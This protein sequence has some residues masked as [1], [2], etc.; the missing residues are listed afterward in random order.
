[1]TMR[2]ISV[3]FILLNMFLWMSFA[4][5]ASKADFVGEWCYRT[6]VD[7]YKVPYATFRISIRENQN[8][9][10]EGQYCSISYHGN[11]IDCSLDDFWNIQGKY[12]KNNNQVN[13]LFSTF[14]EG[15]NGEATLYFSGK[16]LNWRVDKDPMGGH[17]YG[18][19]IAAL[20]KC[21]KE[22]PVL[23]TIRSSK[24]YLRANPS[25]SSSTKG[26]LVKGDIVSLLTVSDNADFFKVRYD[27][28]NGKS[29]EGWIRYQ[30]FGREN[31]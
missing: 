8:A 18:P 2:S 22:V 5:N 28:G 1:M 16:Q 7:P 3:R 13:V 26:Y 29:V 31:E 11:R 23:G 30:E 15:K 19:Y 25:R 12:T 17:F 21:D 9:S 10:L 6:S 27:K 20:Q 4:S 14:F 24:E